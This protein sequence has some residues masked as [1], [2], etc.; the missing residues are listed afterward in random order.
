MSSNDFFDLS[1]VPMFI[2]SKAT[3]DILSMNIAGFHFYGYTEDEVLKLKILDLHTNSEQEFINKLHNSGQVYPAKSEWQQIT[4]EGNAVYVE[5]STNEISFNDQAAI[6]TVV[7]D[8]NDRKLAQLQLKNSENSYLSIINSQE[9]IIFRFLPDTTLLFVNDAYCKQFGL[10]REEI[11]GHKF[12][13][14]VQEK[15]KHRIRNYLENLMQKPATMN[16]EYRE[17]YDDGKLIWWEWTD[18]PIAGVNG[19]IIEIQTVGKNITHKKALEEKQKTSEKINSILLNS[20]PDLVFYI[21]NDGTYLG[22]HTQNEDLLLTEPR[23]FIGKKITEVLPPDL[24]ETSMNTIRKAIET[25][26]PVIYTYNLLIAGKTRNYENRVLPVNDLEVISVIRDITEMENVKNLLAKEKSLLSSILNSIPDI[27]FYKDRQGKYLG[28][29]KS[30]EKF[31]GKSTQ[32]FIGKNDLEIFD[33]QLAEKFIADDLMLFKNGQPVIVEEEVSYV[34]GRYAP[35]ETAKAP[36]YDEKGNIIGIVGTSR[37]IAERKAYERAIHDS[38]ERFDLAIK[39]TKAGLWDW[40]MITDK[41]FYSETWKSMLGYSPSEI[42]ESFDD[43]KVLWHP[44]DVVNNERAINDYLNGITEK[45]EIEHRLRNKSGQYQWILT[46]GVIQRDETG[47]PVRWLGINIDL[48]SKKTLE[49]DLLFRAQLQQILLRLAN[50]LVNIRFESVDEAITSTLKE[51]GNFMGV[52]R[53]YVFSYNMDLLTTS[54]THEWCAEGIS[55]EIENLQDIPVSDLSIWMDNHINGHT[56]VV[57]DVLKLSEDDP[58]R[59]VLEPQQIQSLI[60]VPL[61]NGQKL[62]GFIGFDSVKLKKVWSNTEQ[63][64]LKFFAELIVNL[65]I[66]SNYEN[67]I[68]E[69][70]NMLAFATEAANT[71]IWNWDVTGNKISYNLQMA[72][73][74]GRS[75]DELL[76]S[77]ETYFKF[78]HPDEYEHIIKKIH[79]CTEGLLEN[80]EEE[81][82]ILHADGYYI[83]IHDSGSIIDVDINGK[84]IRISGTRTNITERKTIEIELQKSEQQFRSFYHNAA[85]GLYRLAPD[86]DFILV[87]PAFC[88]ILGYDSAED[89]LQ[90]GLGKV[91]RFRK[92]K[93]NDFLKQIYQ[94]D[95]LRGFESVW[96]KSNGESIYVIENA[97]LIRDAEGVVLYIDGSVEDISIR[98]KAEDALQESEIKFRQLAENVNDIFWLRD[99]KNGETLYVNPAFDKVFG[100]RGSSLHKHWEIVLKMIHPDERDSV[101]KK[102]REYL[103]S[104]SDVFD[105]EFRI[106]TH[107]GE[108][109]WIRATSNA[110]R[111][112]KGKALRHAILASDITRQK[113]VEQQLKFNFEL[114]KQLGELKSRFVSMASHELRTPLATILATTETLKAYR[115]RMEN[116]EI[117]KRFSKII[118]QISHLK[119]IMDDVLSLSKISEGK[120]PFNPH[121]GDMSQVIQEIVD[122]FNSNPDF[123]HE[124]QTIL[125]VS[126]IFDFDH[127]LMRQLIT[128]LLSNAI[129]YSDKEKPIQIVVQKNPETVQFEISDQGIG[130]PE[131]EIKNLFSPYFRASNVDNRQGTGLGM[132]IVKQAVELH[133]GSIEVESLQNIGTKFTCLFPENT[134]N[135]QSQ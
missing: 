43:W 118:E 113:E 125:P 101:D 46:R 69:S 81:Y 33:K 66:R 70:E 67:A 26:Q 44:D 55:P 60:T 25:K 103:V 106:T 115:D 117:D 79:A 129:K 86:G 82:R 91:T 49:N 23:N 87:N 58:L 65:H 8:I 21:Q 18:Y 92:S 71:A 108:N 121:R 32:D 122:E 54:N 35:H 2:F 40:D 5:L 98:K 24:A 27:V 107:Y 104:Q 7:I 31:I 15:E 51:I 57:E 41:V 63:E 94:N 84:P 93:D 99:A 90:S 128:N 130:I 59:M 10:K 42:S 29:N 68:I 17:E 134:Y 126:C 3:L 83:W 61:L 45:Y 123:D 102:Y 105:M 109:K 120:L 116:H 6:L 34:D 78:V 37:N 100:L 111:D 127:K 20:L 132:V 64:L 4:K 14:Y 112:A 85:I 53:A 48:T 36:L 135:Y 114:E 76:S 39:A 95:E 52:D 96:L 80:F 16:Y 110:I 62:L 74:I 11:I 12:L 75:H 133:Q 22:V 50:E 77:P 47:T 89:A 13:E 1:P 97:S 119:R 131:E 88:E 38:E 56:M 72:K 19:E 30:F 28:G 124:I 9:D 73:M